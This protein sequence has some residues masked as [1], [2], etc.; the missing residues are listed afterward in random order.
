MPAS[1]FDATGIPAYTPACGCAS[2][3]GR[4]GLQGSSCLLIFSRVHQRILRFSNGFLRFWCSP[5]CFCVLLGFPGFVRIFPGSSGFVW[6]CQGFSG[7]FRV[8]PGSSG[9]FRVLQGLSGFVRVLRVYQCFSAPRRYQGAREP[10]PGRSRERVGPA[11]GCPG[12]AWARPRGVQGARAPGPG[13]VQ[14][15]RG[16]G[17]GGSRERV[18]PTPGGTRER[19]GPTPGGT[20][21]CV[22]LPQGVSGRS[23]WI[24]PRG[25]LGALGPYPGGI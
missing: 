14:G 7:F 15:A 16:P 17:P 8:C 11:Q 1:S 9:F 18:G 25:Y 4:M 13:R 6:V 2:W 10:C 19:V 20:W 22:G 24:L 21:D 23:A 5:G 12:S 3:D